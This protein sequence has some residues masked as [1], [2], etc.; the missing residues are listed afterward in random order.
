MTNG[1]SYNKMIFGDD[2]NPIDY[3]IL[4]INNAFEKMMGLKKSVLGKRVSEVWPAF[5]EHSAQLLDV[6]GKVAKTGRAARF[7]SYNL[8]RDKWYE[9]LAYS[10]ERGCFATIIEDITK[11]KKNEKILSKKQQ[12]LDLIFDSSPTIIFYKDKDGRFIQVN[13][14]FARALE[15]SKETLLRKTIFDLYS[16]EIAQAMTNDDLEVM[17]LKRSKLG[18]VE[19]YESPTGLRWIRTDKIPSFDENGVVNGLIGFSE[20]ITERKKTEETL[21]ESE[22]KFRNLAEES[23]NMIFINIRGRI[24]YANKKCE[25]VMGYKKEELYLPNFD[26]LT[27]IAPDS[28]SEITSNFQ[29]HLK[30]QEAEQ[31]ECGLMTKGG[32]Q[33]V[34]IL[35]T[36]L[37]KYHGETGI[38]GIVTDIT[39]RKILERKLVQDHKWLT[40]LQRTLASV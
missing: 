2:G 15:V 23:P 31:V 36:K 1:F 4:E 40:Q 22:E 20:D 8:Q 3:I 6:F 32:K 24:I 5:Q 14:A 16:P 30:G 34:A 28:L 7:E 29:N 35:T 26:F 19:P 33:I 13:N 9:I 12:E 17:E 25:D 18:I 21:K 27:L 39:D 37:I 38:L 11:R 10:P